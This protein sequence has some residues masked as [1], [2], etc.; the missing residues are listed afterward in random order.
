[1]A[2]PLK[3]ANRLRV[4]GALAAELPA[5]D[6]GARSWVYVEP[7]LWTGGDLTGMLEGWRRMQGAGRPGEA[8]PQQYHVRYVRLTPWHLEPEQDLAAALR[9]R[10]VPDER[11]EARSEAELV[12]VLSRWLA[13]LNVLRP[14][15][16]AGYPHPPYRY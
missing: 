5:T 6:D 11:A 10:P 9:E 12:Q 14:P 15:G 13:D 16:E 4:G 8:A 2:L 7:V 3:V 1:M